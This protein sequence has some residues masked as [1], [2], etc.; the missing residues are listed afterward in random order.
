MWQDAAES[1]GG[2]DE[3]VKF[4]VASDGQLQVAGR[5][6]LDLEIFG[7]V[8]RELKHFGGEVFEDGSDIDRGC[9]GEC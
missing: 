1:D 6:A 2:T 7:R 5:D 8:S 9:E 4:L 3:R